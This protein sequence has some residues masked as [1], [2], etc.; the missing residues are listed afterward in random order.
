MVGVG[1]VVVVVA[2]LVVWVGVGGGLAVDAGLVWLRSLTGCS[3]V[4]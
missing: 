1:V 4:P 2:G 3:F